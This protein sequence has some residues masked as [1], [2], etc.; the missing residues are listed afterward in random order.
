MIHCKRC[1]NAIASSFAFCVRCGAPTGLA[2]L[3][4]GKPK[5]HAWR[6]VLGISITLVALA[7]ILVILVINVTSTNSDTGVVARSASDVQAVDTG[8]KANDMMLGFLKISSHT[9]LVPSSRA[10]VIAARGEGRFMLES[11]REIELPTGPW[12]APTVKLI[13]SNLPLTQVAVPRSW[14]VIF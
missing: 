13:K 5:G 14:I 9:L 3:Q 4:I 7:V 12:A 8:N 10:L 2:V 11:P 6:T 1:N